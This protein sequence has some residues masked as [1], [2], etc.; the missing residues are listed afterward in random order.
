MRKSITEN[1]SPCCEEVLETMFFTGILSAEV[2]TVCRGA[3]DL[4]ASVRFE[5]PPDGEL[6]VC[7]PHQTGSALA[8]SFLGI[9]P[10][11]VTNA[12]CEQVAGELANMFCGSLLSRSAPTSEFHLDVT[13]EQVPNPDPCDSCVA[14]ELPEGPLNVCVRVDRL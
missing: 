7:I 5:G 6:R 10:D 4:H 9:V 14:F 12:D 1:L 8:S 3:G 13:H 11:E 2:Q